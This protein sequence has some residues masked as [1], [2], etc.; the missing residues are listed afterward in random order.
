MIQTTAFS[1]SHTDLRR[2]FRVGSTVVLEATVSYPSLTCEDGE[3]KLIQNGISRFNE[4]YRAMAE[5]FLGW[6]EGTLAEDAKGDFS[7]AG[8]GA[9]YTF[10]RRLVTCR[11][12]AAPDGDGGAVSV[13]RSVTLGSRRGGIWVSREQS[14]RWRADLSLIPARRRDRPS[15]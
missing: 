13:R 12:E 7:A 15:R 3:N 9:V 8:A 6:C 2:L 11:M 1:V 10:D 5:A 14:D 4:V